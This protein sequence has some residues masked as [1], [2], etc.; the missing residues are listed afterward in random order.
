MVDVRLHYHAIRTYLVAVL[1]AKL[2]RFADN[3]LVNGC[4]SLGLYSLHVLLQRRLL[5]RLFVEADSAEG[6]IRIRVGKREGEALVAQPGKLLQHRCA[7]HLLGS[8]PISAFPRI[9]AT[10]AS[11]A[12]ILV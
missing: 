4:P 11:P 1:D 7:K 3:H 8:H 5:R 6:A 12:Q 10:L 2:V 9:D